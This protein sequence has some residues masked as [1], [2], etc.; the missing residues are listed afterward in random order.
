MVIALAIAGHAEDEKP[1]KPPPPPEDA[2][3]PQ[4]EDADFQNRMKTPAATPQ[5]TSKEAGDQFRLDL[6]KGPDETLA[7][8]WMRDWFTR[9][10]ADKASFRQGVPAIAVDADNGEATFIFVPQLMPELK[11]EATEF[12]SCIVRLNRSTTRI[13]TDEKAALC[14]ILFSYWPKELLLMDRGGMDDAVSSAVNALIESNLKDGTGLWKRGMMFRYKADLFVDKSKHPTLMFTVRWKS[15][16]QNGY[17]EYA[18]RIAASVKTWKTTNAP[19]SKKPLD[20]LV[21]RALGKPEK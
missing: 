5:S 20:I 17:I 15:D 7:D 14:E 4:T 3:L 8:G 11:A 1:V 18:K 10:A 16:D 12:M 19:A 9:F 6:S 13:S 2:R 21:A